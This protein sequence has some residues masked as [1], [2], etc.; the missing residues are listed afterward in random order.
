[1]FKQRKLCHSRP[2]IITYSLLIFTQLQDY[3]QNNQN[4]IVNQISWNLE[5]F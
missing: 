5:I 1:M 3:W 2:D 4:I